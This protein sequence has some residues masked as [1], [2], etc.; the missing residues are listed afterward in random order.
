MDDSTHYFN[1]EKG[2]LVAV[3]KGFLKFEDF[4]DISNQSLVLL[5]QYRTH[6]LLV[7]T[8]K[9]KVM[10][11]QNRKWIQEEWFPKAIQLGLKKMAFITP[12]NIFGEV[13]MKET[14]EK[15][16]GEVPIDLKYF[17]SVHDAE[18]WLVTP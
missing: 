16:E 9:F 13:T 7:D 5:K 3:Y 14:N 2:F 11:P 10:P 18:R 1:K 4:Q 6:K 17:I 8:S 12:E 15:V